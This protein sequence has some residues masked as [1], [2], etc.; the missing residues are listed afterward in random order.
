MAT[1]RKL[2][3]IGHV[4]RGLF[5]AMPPW[6]IPDGFSPFVKNVDSSRA[7]GSASKRKGIALESTGPVDANTKVTGLHEYRPVGAAVVKFASAGNDIY[8]ATVSGAWVSRYVGVMAGANVNFVTFTG[9][10]IAVS[11]TEATKKSTGAAFSNL[12]GTPPSNAKFILVFKNRLVILSSSAGRSRVHWSA[13]GA[14]EDW[15][16]ASGAGFQ[17]LDDNDGDEIT[18][19]AVVGSVVVIFKRRAAYAM[20]GVGPPNDT[21]V[22]RKIQAPTGCVSGRSVVSYGNVVVYLSDTGVHSISEALVWGNLSPNIR[23]DIEAL[24]KTG[25]AGGALRRNY[26]LAYDS[27]ADGKND[28]AYK[29]DLENGTWDQWT[30][31]DVSVF[32][33]YND[34]SLISGAS[35]VK[36]LRKHDQGE[37][38]EGVAIDWI[39]RGRSFDPT[40]ISGIRTGETAWV[41]MTPIADKKLTVRT[42]TDGI[43]TDEQEVSLTATLLDGQNRDTRSAVVDLPGGTQGRMLALEFRNNELAAPIRLYRYGLQY[44]VF[45]QQDVDT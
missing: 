33:T 40:D 3:E 23:Y 35:D 22:F 18:G 28:S 20:L 26:I 29:L 9:L 11:E 4:H 10:C 30:N 42:R 1:S 44:N 16:V 24:S 12:L 25:A 37:D 32:A 6:M 45:D 38:D 7:I 17:D 27:D 5:T 36:N 14:P 13:P 8:D 21:F 19:A 43:Q 15:T 31:I 34:G 2:S 41:E 39:Y